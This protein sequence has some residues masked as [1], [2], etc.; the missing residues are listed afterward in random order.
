[1][2]VIDASSIIYAWDN[3]PPEQFPPLWRWLGGEVRDGRI[4][5]SKVAFDQVAKN[6]GDCA[7]WL[8]LHG[9]R[10]LP[11]TNAIMQEA[12]RIKQL[13][14]IEEDKYH[15][16][17][18][19]EEDVLIIATA[20][21]EHVELVTNEEVQNNLP[22]NPA[23]MKIPAVC[24]LDEVGVSCINFITLVKESREVFGQ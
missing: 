7:D 24:G 5:M 10:R 15:K 18:V 23:R 8:R 6:A 11:V 22:N 2:R 12:M 4:V 21:V 19:D 17:G 13:L 1:M 16:R 14:G 20:S 3:Y 9:V